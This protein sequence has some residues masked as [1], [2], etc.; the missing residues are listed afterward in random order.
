[1]NSRRRE[2][3]QSVADP[4]ETKSLRILCAEDDDQVARLLKIALECSGHSVDCVAD[5]QQALERIAS[6]LD[7]FDLLVTD[8]DM[9]QLSGLDLVSKL[10]DTAF[11][12]SII[13]H[14]SQLREVDAAAYRRFAVDRIFAKP[15]QLSEFLEAVRQVG[16][17]AS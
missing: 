13:V 12:G 1:M 15:V 10:R 5:G 14:S 6:D 17:F 11:A 7:F 4:H 2:T 9:P 3:S 16:A 8:H